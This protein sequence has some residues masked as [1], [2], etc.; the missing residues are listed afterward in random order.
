MSLSFTPR[1]NAGLS[2][3]PLASSAPGGWTLDESR[4]ARESLPPAQ[5]LSSSYYEIWYAALVELLKS[6]DLVNDA[7]LRA[8]HPANPGRDGLRVLKAAD[9]AETLGRGGPTERETT[10]EARFAPGDRVRARVINPATHT[11]L[12]RYAR[13]RTGIVHRVHGV[14]VF[15]DSNAS[16]RGEDPQWLYN[17]RFEAAELWGPDSAKGSAVHIDLWEP[18]LEPA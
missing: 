10:A 13:G 5:Y 7:E 16:G 15:A 9:V 1:G 17:V 18:H 4:F 8:G 6:R 3:L 11:R 12:P 14:H 2:R